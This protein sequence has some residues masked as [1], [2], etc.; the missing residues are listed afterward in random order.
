MNFVAGNSEELQEI[1]K[2]SEE[3]KRIGMKRFG[4]IGSFRVRNFENPDR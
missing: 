2:D 4:E 3:P 1:A